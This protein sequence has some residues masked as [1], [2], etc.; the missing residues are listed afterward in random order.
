MSDLTSEQRDALPGGGFAVPEKRKLPIHDEHHIRLAWQMVDRTKGLTSEERA[1]ARRVILSAAAERG[2]DTSGWAASEMTDMVVSPVEAITDAANGESGPMVVR[3]RAT[4]VNTLNENNRVYPDAV[5]SDAVER[6]NA[7]YV[8]QGRMIGESPHPKAIKAPSGKI[9]FDTRLENSVIKVTNL[10]KDGADVFLDAE[11][12]NT[13]KG[14]DLR[15]MLRQKAWP[16]ISMRAL[17]DSVRRE[18]NGVMADVATYL[19]IQSFDVVMNP[20]TDGCGALAVLTDSQ[21]EQM[22]DA[23]TYCCHDCSGTLTEMDPDDDGDVDFLACDTCGCA[24]VL[25]VHVEQQTAQTTTLSKVAPHDGDS[26]PLAVEWLERQPKQMTDSVKEG[27]IVNKDDLVNAMQNEPA[28]RAVVAELA[29]QIAKPALD[30]VEAQKEKDAKATA[31]ADAKAFLDGKI[32]TLKG[33]FDEKAIEAIVD[34]IGMPDTVQV[35]EALFNSAV[36]LAGAQAAKAIVDSVGFDASNVQQKGHVRVEVGSSP[37]P[38][39]PVVDAICKEMDEYGEQY[40]HAVDPK[41]RA[42]N[43]KNVIDKVLPHM[44]QKYGAKAFT[45]S[46]KLF[47]DGV[48]GSELT[49]DSVSV[50]TQ[51]LLNQPTILTA[52][53][54]QAFQ[55]VEST[56]F[57]FT[58]VFLGSEWRVPVETFTSAAAYNPNTGLLDLA[59][60]EGAGIS[61]SAIKINWTSFSPT[62]RRNAVNLTTDVIRQ[63]QT[64]PANYGAIARAIYHISEDKKRKLD[65]AAYLEMIMASDEYQ[66]LAITN[67]APA[68]NKVIT[69][70]IPG[71]SN[72]AYR[73]FLEP[74]TANPVQGYNPVVRP[75]TTNQIQPGGQIST[76]TLNPVEVKVGATVLVLGA[77]D[78]KNIVSFPGTTAQA[79]IDFEA[80]IV[81]F[82][83]TAVSGVNPTAGTPVLPTIS[84]SAVTNYDRWSSTMA[85]GYTDIAAYYDTF[86]QQLSTTAALMGSSP[87]FKKPNLALFSLNAATFVENARIFYKWASPDGTKLIDTGNT[88]GT[89]A[90]MNLSR[91]NAP[92]VA[93]D[94]RILLTQKGSTRYGIETPY[95]MEGPFPVYDASGNIVDAKVWYGRENSVLATPQVADANL[96]IINPVSRTIIIN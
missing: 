43:R 67:E 89:R 81:Y 40:G 10:F 58:D 3:F 45:D 34:S 44:E 54:V 90:G 69:T 15:A 50:T 41:L 96:N 29:G 1:S 19:D 68:A 17:G 11:V 91:I 28:V 62:W 95:E 77:W 72:A 92:W 32:D 79:A 46:A 20:A 78:G 52:V 13:Q 49:T 14:R 48:M 83:A 18:V 64:G 25:D 4:R 30:A 60:A 85:T 38:W 73:C 36:K 66:P 37:Q 65:N 12:L 75:R 2:M 93:G 94:S 51:T 42:L 9:V 63:L 88:F 23:P 86:L 47:T 53:L 61:A 82:A 74:A 59:V 5:M 6:A 76:V 21:I 27:E 35:A 56:Q 8:K 26:F 70:G 57:M 71:G 31:K 24:Y 16:G 22:L 84:Y 55:D 80:G 33:K 7:A 87:R 39:R